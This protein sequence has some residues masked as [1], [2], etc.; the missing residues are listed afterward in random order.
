MVV[1]TSALFAVLLREP[2]S[3]I[4]AEA[5]EAEAH[6][7]IAAATLVEAGAVALGRG[8]FLLLQELEL[9]ILESEFEIISFSAQHAQIATEAYRRYGRGIGN[10][11]CLNMGDC[12][13]YALARA[14]DQPLLYKGDD[15]AR[16]DIRSAL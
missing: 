1:D 4:Y 12:F 16:T 11:A 3:H 5:I 13:S 9:L 2:D 7:R 8:G 14:L 6:P 10:P 15:F